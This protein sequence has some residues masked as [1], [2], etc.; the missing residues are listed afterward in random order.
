MTQRYDQLSKLPLNS[1]S[2]QSADVFSSQGVLQIRPLSDGIGLGELKAATVSSATVS[3]ATVSRRQ[4]SQSSGNMS[5]VE[6]AVTRQAQAAYAPSSVA[7]EIR[8]RTS[9]RWFV[10]GSRFIAGWGVDIFVGV[11]SAVVLTWACLLAWNAGAS[12]EFRP[13]DSILTMTDAIESASTLQI[14]FGV[15]VALVFWRGLRLFFS[16]VN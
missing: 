5:Q 16:R 12:G 15:L 9:T 4:P 14:V 6:R 3:S 8:N 1:S 10:K 2:K 7:N 13:I 11:L